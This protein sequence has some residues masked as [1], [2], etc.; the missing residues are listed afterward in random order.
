MCFGLIYF[1]K[2]KSGC[3][4]SNGGFFSNDSASVDGSGDSLASENDVN[5]ASLRGKI[6]NHASIK[7]SQTKLIGTL[8]S[9]KLKSI[10][11][12]ILVLSS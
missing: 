9:Q 4:N 1:K 10:L 8:L 11:I 5:V 3:G 12:L 2:A 7:G 6:L